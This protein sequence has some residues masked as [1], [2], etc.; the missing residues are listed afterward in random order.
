MTQTVSAK[1]ALVSGLLFLEQPRMLLPLVGIII[2]MLI[3]IYFGIYQYLGLYFQNPLNN[4]YAYQAGNLT[5]AMAL[6][7][8]LA[9]ILFLALFVELSI[10]IRYVLDNNIKSSM[11]S[12]LLVSI[13]NYPRFLVSVLLQGLLIAGGAILLIVPAFYLGS[14]ALFVSILS[15]YEEQGPFSALSRSNKLTKPIFSRCLLVFAF[16]VILGL[17]FMYLWANAG[18]STLYVFVLD[19]VTLSFI[20]IAYMVSS[21]S[22]LNQLKK[23]EYAR[24]GFSYLESHIKSLK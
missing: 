2:S 4:V 19:S 22:L 3:L 20:L 17:I 5:V 16:Y 15:I 21:I 11:L 10:M 7:F 9:F 6:S 23:S 24:S 18:L 14:R 1:K 12:I 8:V 13:K